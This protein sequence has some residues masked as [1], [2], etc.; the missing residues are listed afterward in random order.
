MDHLRWVDE[1]RVKGKLTG[2]GEKEGEL[3]NEIIENVDIKILKNHIRS[4]S[5]ENDSKTRKN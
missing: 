2:G 3:R 5:E 1:V 4:S